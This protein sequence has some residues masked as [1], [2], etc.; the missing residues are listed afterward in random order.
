MLS[1]CKN[2]ESVSLAMAK[3]PPKVHRPWQI[4]PKPQEGRTQKTL[5]SDGK[6]FYQS[7]A[8]RKTRA[9]FLR[10][11]V[12]CVMCTARGIV[13]AANT[14]DHI[15]PIRQGGDPYAFE[16]LQQLCQSCH[17]SKS[18]SEKSLYKY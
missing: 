11:N 6:P 17:N 2:Q 10:D 18:G 16:N 3:L 13:T 15:V 12:L 9:A 5:T 4:K 7:T 8:W 1:L 14:V